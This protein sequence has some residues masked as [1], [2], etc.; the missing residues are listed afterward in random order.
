[1]LSDSIELPYTEGGEYAYLTG[2]WG[3]LKWYAENWFMLSARVPV[4][5]CFVS[6]Y[7]SA[8]RGVCYLRSAVDPVALVSL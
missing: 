8:H 3:R 4:T 6:P 7:V 5:S 1:L 2:P